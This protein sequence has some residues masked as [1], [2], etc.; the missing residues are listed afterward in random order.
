MDI[1]LLLDE[2]AATARREGRVVTVR[3]EGD[4]VV[5][6]RVQ[7]IRRAIA[8]VLVNALR[9]GRTV[10]AA[11]R[12]LGDAIE[13]TI[14][15]DGPGIPRESREEVFRPFFRLDASRNPATGGVGLGLAI[16]RDIMRGH[17]GDAT[18]EE[19]P[20]GGARAKLRLPV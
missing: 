7:A 17:G 15:D 18:I 8:N 3:T 1:G 20:L 19:S 10:A 11:A 9:H 13:I 12:R 14:D 5:P 16:V 2:V 4:L 6:A